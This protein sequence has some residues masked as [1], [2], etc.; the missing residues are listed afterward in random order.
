MTV[1]VFVFVFVL[2]L[3]AWLCDS[4]A[5]PGWSTDMIC[6]SEADEAMLSKGICGSRYYWPEWIEVAGSP[7][8][9]AHRARMEHARPLG[10]QDSG[11]RR[12]GGGDMARQA[13]SLTDA[14]VLPLECVLES[15]WKWTE[16][17]GQQGSS[18]PSLVLLA[19]P[20][21]ARRRLLRQKKIVG[22][23]RAQQMAS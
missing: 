19:A 1:M 8:M 22:C 14:Q 5:C 10:M 4:G 7:G 20:P 18:T 17:A 16:R 2:A 12:G 15:R 21:T 11:S 9:E 3:F 13:R 23:H 6:S